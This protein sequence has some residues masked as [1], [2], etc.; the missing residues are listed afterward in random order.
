MNPLWDYFWPVFTAGLAAGV[1]FG[2]LAY[3]RWARRIGYWIAGGAVAVGIAL[4]WHGPLGAANRFATQVDRNAR[5]TLIDNYIPQISAHLHRGPLTRRIILAGPA[6]DF[7][8]SELV[9]IMGDL[10]GVSDAQ[11]SAEPGGVPLI[12]EAAAAALVGFLFGLVLAYLVELRRRYNAQWN[13]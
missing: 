2:W 8:S 9:R 11:W 6:D 12:A 13:W 10:P 5:A 3:R 4:A 7:Q 1:V